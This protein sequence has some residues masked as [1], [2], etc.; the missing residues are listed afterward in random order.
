[1]KRPVRTS[2]LLYL[3]LITCLIVRQAAADTHPAATISPLWFS[4]LAVT[5]AIAL[6]ER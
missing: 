3:M 2:Q 1:M 6:N 5:V 4:Y